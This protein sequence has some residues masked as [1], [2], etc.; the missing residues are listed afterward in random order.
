MKG[1]RPREHCVPDRNQPVLR[2][3][4]GTWQPLS[5]ELKSQTAASWFPPLL[6]GCPANGS[7]LGQGTE[8]RDWAQPGSAGRLSLWLTGGP[9][10]ARLWPWPHL[11]PQ[12][13]RLPP[14][15]GES[16]PSGPAMDRAPLPEV[17]TGGGMSLTRP[18]GETS[19]GPRGIDFGPTSQ[20]QANRLLQTTW[21][22]H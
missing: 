12:P 10:A 21:S 19:E 2:D 18:R 1:R 15:A 8:N 17:P 6:R 9:L 13:R 20:T 11:H 4:V 22:H 16:G 14:S 7:P 3:R 5:V